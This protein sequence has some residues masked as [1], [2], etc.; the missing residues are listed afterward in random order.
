[1]TSAAATATGM[2]PRSILDVPRARRMQRTAVAV[3]T[4]LLGLL[5]Y[6]LCWAAGFITLP[7]A[8]AATF[9]VLGCIALFVPVFYTGAN[10]GLRDPSLFLPQ[11]MCAVVVTS[12][13]MA[14]AGPA[15]PALTILYLAALILSAIRFN[16]RTYTALA[17]F[18][19]LSYAAVIAAAM[20]IDGVRFDERAEWL[21][22]LF[23]AL[24]LPWIGW[25]GTF[26]ERLRRRTR[27]SE[28]VYRVIWNTS[29]NAIV[30]FDDT[31]TIRLVNPAAARLFD[32]SPAHMTGKPLT[33]F[34]PER[35]RA[36]LVQDLAA[37]LAGDKPASDWSLMAG[38]VL[39]AAGREV[40][41]EAEIVELGSADPAGTLF[42]DGHRRLALFASDISQ[43]HAL[44]KIKDDFIAT[45]S[46][47]LRNPLTAIVGAVEALQEDTTVQLQPHAGSLLNMAAD[48][49]GRLQRLIDTMLHLQKMDTGGIDFSP[50]PVDAAELISAALA[51]A[52]ELAAIQG[53]YL[54]TTRL[55][56]NAIVRADRRWIHQVLLNLIDNAL[57]F[58][59][60]GA[61]VVVG[62]AINGGSVRFSVIDQ[63]TGV[64][65]E[66][67]GRVFTRFARAGHS[68]ARAQGGAAQGGAGLGLS[69][70][71]AAV[72]GC[73]G[74]IGYTN[75][76]LR[77]A[78]FWFDLP[79][80]E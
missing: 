31:G 59:P 46:L 64:P 20:R 61:S 58:S 72:E 75:H 30:I 33:D 19:L 41:V 76:P 28:A 60:A 63:G 27:A 1:M 3:A 14:Y 55:K 11:S 53:K 62:A 51:A 69:L 39:T 52:R 40:P 47:E 66:L 36:R 37:Y 12:Y 4:S 78:T 35:L 54:M 16:L 21:Q 6:W 71:K 73:G 79:L 13:V 15:R 7:V 26:L 34:A 50:E 67:A 65:P 25:L 80:A 48:G 44:E 68:S 24:A 49:A 5:M 74:A 70:C 10:L 42:D 9:A 22:W 32:S 57:N 23:M 45:V 18:T 29:V 17:V 43:R 38:I 56:Q 2:P 8:G 77:G